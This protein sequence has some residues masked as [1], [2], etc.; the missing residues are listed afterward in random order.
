MDI[1]YGSPARSAFVTNV[2]LITSSGPHGH[3]IMSAEWT[4]QLS[5]DPGLLGV[6]IGPK[7]ATHDN[8]VAAKYFGVSI[9]A[10]DQNVLASIAGNSTGKEVD[11]IGLLKELGFSFK[12]SEHFDL[13]MPEGSALS[14]ECELVDQLT[15][16]DHVLFVGKAMTIVHN[17]A[18]KPLAYHEGKYW[19]VGAEL[20]KPSPEE[21]KH[22]DALKEKFR[23]K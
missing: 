12:K 16:G 15:C 14:A 18:R 6:S 5:Y 17:A 11:K 13:W 21:R 8:I 4:F 10:E 3:N 19:H 23:K 1:K 7:K 2:G 20:Q 22:M 9:A